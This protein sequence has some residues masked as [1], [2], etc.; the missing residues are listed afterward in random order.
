MFN[1]F[2]LFTLII[3]VHELGHFLA[4]II[5]GW[6]VEKITIYPYGGCT[7]FNTLINVSFFEE[8]FV[9][10]MGPIIQ[11]CFYLF[12]SN[13]LSFNDFLIFKR[14]NYFIL[15]FN[16]LPIYPLDGGRLLNLFLSLITPYKKGLRISIILSFFFLFIII[17]YFYSF[18]LLIIGISLFINIINEFNNINHVYN[19]FLLERLLNDF[20]YRRI[21]IIKN[22]NNFYKFYKHLILINNKYYF[23]KEYLEK[24]NFKSKV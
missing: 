11:I 18:S 1:S 19:K 12:L 10:V 13:K 16:L 7:F 15:I 5:L 22:P 9:L 14:Y 23:E 2:F 20:K 6:S 17:L 4:A 3:I 24:I 21:K 8:L